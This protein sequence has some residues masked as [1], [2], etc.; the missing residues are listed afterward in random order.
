MTDLG[1]VPESLARRVCD[2]AHRDLDTLAARRVLVTGASGFFGRWLVSV[3]LRASPGPSSITVLSRGAESFAERWPEGARDGR[4][5]FLGCDVRD[6]PG[7]D[8]PI[9]DVFHF[10]TSADAKLNSEEPLEM[11]DVAFG[12][13]RR[14]LDWS[15]RAGVERFLFASSGAVYGPQPSSVERISEDFAGAPDP[16]DLRTSYHQA[17]R[18]AEHL[19]AVHS[20][21]SGPACTIARCFAFGGPGLPL[22]RHFA[23]GN[24]V[25]D[26]A[27]GRRIRVSGDGR[28]I[29]SY[30]DAEDLMVWLLAIFAR[31][32][33][34]RAYNV[35]SE[36]AVTI[37]Q[38]AERI[39]A[40]GEVPFGVEG[41]QEVGPPHRYVPSTARIEGELGV[42]RRVSLDETI[43]RALDWARQ[44]RGNRE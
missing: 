35:G 21:T 11:F 37:R 29:R 12:G 26:A 28:A 44:E 27:F 24:F 19:C 8:S 34:G 10:A 14:L 9:D 18:A 15:R 42:E 23:F 38:L 3:L 25:G 41:A 36:E 33:P 43:E 17:K 4:V 39:A 40:I 7:L 1:L 30:L 20:A 22:D 6:F 16:L 32:R 31:G 13:T 2:R 5:R